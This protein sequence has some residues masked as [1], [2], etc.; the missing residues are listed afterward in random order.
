M[1]RTSVFNQCDKVG[2]IAIKYDKIIQNEDYYAIQGHS[3][4]WYQLKGCIR[5]PIS[6]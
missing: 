3:R 1:L 6:D 4:C 2:T 5:L